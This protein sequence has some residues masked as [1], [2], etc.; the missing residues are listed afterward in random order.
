MRITYER[1]IAVWRFTCAAAPICR[2][3][4]GCW[5]CIRW[6]AGDGER[7]RIELHTLHINMRSQVTTAPGRRRRRC[8][9]NRQT[10]MMLLWD[11]HRVTLRLVG[12]VFDF[13]RYNMIR[14]WREQVVVDVV[15]IVVIV[16]VFFGFS[17][18]WEHL[19]LA[20]RWNDYGRWRC[21]LERI[22]V[23]CCSIDSIDSS[24]L[25]TK[26]MNYEWTAV[27]KRRER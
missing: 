22:I 4:R 7:W 25:K 19:L 20:R 26:K 6:I 8:R 5:R 24:G 21:W 16:V 14:R 13:Q 18:M 2:R 12:Y 15:V 3:R 23:G 9:L 27:D 1:N 11:D 17:L 10:L